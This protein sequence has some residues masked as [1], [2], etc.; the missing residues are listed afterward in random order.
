M[1]DINVLQPCKVFNMNLTRSCLTVI[2]HSSMNFVLVFQKSTNQNTASNKYNV[3][4]GQF[5]S[6]IWF[7]LMELN[8]TFNNI[9]VISWLSFLLVEETGVPGENHRPVTDKL[10]HIMLYRVHLAC[11]GVSAQKSYSKFVYDHKARMLER[12]IYG[13]IFVHGSWIQQSLPIAH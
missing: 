5:Q 11:A 9:S 3:L 10:Y 1:S 6:N 12:T 7:R 4:I 13:Y 8:A 2:E